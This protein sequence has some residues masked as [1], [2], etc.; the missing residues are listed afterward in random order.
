MTYLE[1][2]AYSVCLLLMQIGYVLGYVTLYVFFHNRKS[3]S[4]GDSKGFHVK[5]KENEEYQV[6]YS[7]FDCHFDVHLHVCVLH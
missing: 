7:L 6:S 1:I 2:N 3:G 5:I 4:E